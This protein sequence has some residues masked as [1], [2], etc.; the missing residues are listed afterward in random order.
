LSALY[1]FLSQI[2]KD[3][4]RSICNITIGHVVVGKRSEITHPAF[5]ALIHATNLNT[6]RIG[7][8]SLHSYSKLFYDI[9]VGEAARR[10]FPV[11]HVWIEQ[12]ERNMASGGKDWRD[13][14][15]LDKRDSFGCFWGDDVKF[16]CSQFCKDIEKLLKE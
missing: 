16:S 15:S 13:V 12:M 7:F 3:A 6:L 5:T 11:A 8:L 1:Y 2:G 4:V 9:K 10:F 14:L